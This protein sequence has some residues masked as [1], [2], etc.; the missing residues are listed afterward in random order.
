MRLRQAL[1]HWFETYVRRN[2][3]VNALE[4][5]AASLP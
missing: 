1:A 3:T 2:Q 4:A 5:L